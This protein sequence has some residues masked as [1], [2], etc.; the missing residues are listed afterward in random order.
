MSKIC[1]SWNFYGFVFST[2]QIELWDRNKKDFFFI[3]VFNLFANIRRVTG[4]RTQNH[5][6]VADKNKITLAAAA[7]RG[8]GDGCRLIISI[9]FPLENVIYKY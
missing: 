2:L 4:T 9:F 5:I 3:F 1:I 8:A 7:L 6:N